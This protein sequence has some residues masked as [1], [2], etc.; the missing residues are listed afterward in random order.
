VGPL[1]TSSQ[2]YTH[3]FTVIDRT[4]RWAEA[5]PLASTT[6]DSCASALIDGWVSRFGVPSTISSDRGPQFASSVWAA[7]CKQ[8]G[9]KHIMTT[10]YHPQSNG[11]VERFHRQLKAA[12]RARD[13]GPHW[14]DHLPWIL[15]GLRAAPKED[16]GYSSAE[17]VFGSRLTLPGEL[18][19][20]SP[21][22]QSE[23]LV[24]PQPPRPHDTRLAGRL[25]PAPPPSVPASLRLAS[26]VYV[27]RGDNRPPLAQLYSGP[28]AVV[29]RQAKYFILQIGGDQQA[30]SVDRLK[31]HTGTATF[32]PSSPPRR[33]RPAASRSTDP[34]P[35]A[36]GLGGA[37]V[38]TSN[39]PPAAAGNPRSSNV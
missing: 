5:V 6:A 17:L 12:F 16:S 39:A 34:N 7:F 19:Q 15:L 37:P 14:L 3:L 33:G 4:T 13:C 1:P 32:L 31:P 2:G 20:P 11:M 18:Q 35:A 21:P 28:Y 36:C 27:R 10:A 26:H 8:M 22:V 24:P 25:Q 30:V 38:A 9:V 29:E 23:L